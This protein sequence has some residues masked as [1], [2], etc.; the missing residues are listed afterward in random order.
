MDNIKK[1]NEMFDDEDL[2]SQFEIPFLK[3][4]MGDEVKKW[5]KVSKPQEI[6][7]PDSLHK[8]IMFR[9]PILNY[10]NEEV[11]TLPEGQNVHCNY[12]TSSEPAKDGNK[13]YAQLVT[14]YNDGVYYINIILRDTNDY[15]DESKWLRYDYE[16]QDIND[17]Y[18]LGQSFLTSC[19]KLGIIKP[20]QKFPIDAN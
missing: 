6:E 15:D 14:S 11:S 20:S 9:F 17:I 3:G 7:T 5:K 1:F 19:E 18:D 16:L 13:Y 2:K 10:F 4:E 8:K 12:V